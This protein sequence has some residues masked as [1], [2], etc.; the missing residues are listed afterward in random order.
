MSGFRGFCLVASGLILLVSPNVCSRAQEPA[1]L[2]NLPVLRYEQVPG[3]FHYIFRCTQAKDDTPAALLTGEPA[4]C[5]PVG[6]AH[7]QMIDGKIDERTSPTVVS[8]GTLKVSKSQVS[9]IPNV[10]SQSFPKLTFASSDVSFEHPNGKPVAFIATKTEFY[11]FGLISLCNVCATV[12]PPLPD[13]GAALDAEFVEIGD[14]IRD[15]EGHLTRYL[16]LTSHLRFGVTPE[17]QPG[18]NATPDSLK[19]YGDLN[20]NMAAACPEPAKSCLQSYAKYQ[21]CSAASKAESCGPAPGCSAFCALA[22]REY[23][24]LAA[25]VRLSPMMSDNDYASLSPRVPGA[26]PMPLPGAVGMNIGVMMGGLLGGTGNGGSQPREIKMI[27]EES[28]PPPLPGGTGA[29]PAHSPRIASGIIAGLK[30]S[31]V[32]PVYPAVA[33]AAHVQ[34]TVILHAIISKQG[35]IERLEVV[36]GPPLLMSAA[37]DA[38][39]TWTYKPYLLNGEPAEV[40]TTVIVNFNLNGDPASAPAATPATN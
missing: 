8:Q 31:G 30:V 36:S 3:Y 5:W 24:K 34:G 18:A 21:S 7:F 35:R 37:L 40:D 11:K 14:S 19:L 1:L 38:V 26:A 20:R 25:D 28:P 15:F 17:N 4:L 27:K 6:A 2:R 39:K 29:G 13:T 33:Q 32:N 10:P 22:P 16:E 23:Q 12:T 9:F